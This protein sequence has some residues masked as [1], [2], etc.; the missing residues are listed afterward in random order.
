MSEVYSYQIVHHKNGIKTD[1]RIQN[2]ELTTMG[3]HIIDHSLGYRD[4]Y[5]KGLKDGAG[6]CLVNVIQV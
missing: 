2:L 4:G 6:G 3:Q 1:N 5:A